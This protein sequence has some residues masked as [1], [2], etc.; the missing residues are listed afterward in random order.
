MPYF[1]KPLPYILTLFM[2]VKVSLMFGFEFALA[3]PVSTHKAASDEYLQIWV[4]KLE[5]QT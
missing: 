4:R 1:K 5:N 3:S 2:E